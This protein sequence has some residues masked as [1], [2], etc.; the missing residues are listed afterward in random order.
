VEET[1]VPIVAILMVFGSPILIVWMI[2]HYRERSR[3]DNI[4]APAAA[5]ANN[6]QLMAVA[7]KMEHRIDALEQILDVE[8]PGWRKKYHEHS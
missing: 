3:R 5:S 6:A 8:A 1:V 4:A 2:M 7:E